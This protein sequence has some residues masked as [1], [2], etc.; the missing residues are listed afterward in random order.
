M[1]FEVGW[2]DPGR[3]KLLAA[4]QAAWGPTDGGASKLQEA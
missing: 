4:T 3:M 2:L 1:C